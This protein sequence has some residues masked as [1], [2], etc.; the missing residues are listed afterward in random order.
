VNCQPL[1]R[2][3]LVEDDPSW[4][5]IL[6]EILRDAGLAVDA[7]E[8]LEQAVA[9][10]RAVSHRLAIVDL[11]LGGAG[12]GNQDGL[13]VLE[14][15][16]RHDPLCVPVMLT[17]FA[18]VELAVSVLADYG[19]LS[20]LRKEAFNRSEFMD[21]L[22]RALAKPPSR[23]VSSASGPE[24]AASGLVGGGSVA[25]LAAPPALP[26][27][28][29][30]NDAGWRD[31]LSE[32][33]ADAG[34]RS[35]VCGSFGEALGC[36]RRESYA[37]AIVDLCLGVGESGAEPRGRDLTDRGHEGH[38]LLRRIRAAGI[39][40][41]VVSG[42]SAPEDIERAYSDDGVFAYL[43]KQTFDRRIFL[44]AITEALAALPV[45]ADLAQLTDREREVLMLL[46][47][48]RTNKEIAAELVITPNTVKRHLKAIFAKLQ[49]HTRSA[50]A[51]QAISSGLL[52]PDGSPRGL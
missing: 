30:E 9:A 3:L 29:V 27:L 49:V 48:G 31:I 19:A 39:P 10:L 11:A 40:A 50:A 5:Q 41:I 33:L 52:I 34:Y 21:L 42:L 44:Q 37:L 16:R 14:S 2:A 18:T 28:V 17:G 45:C 26:L 24:V 22:R 47:R 25:T 4:Q 35:R 8:G 7:V 6:G 13:R 36:L 20:C 1:P 38:H 51:A 12:A 43:E 46:A 23:S 15:L 32:L